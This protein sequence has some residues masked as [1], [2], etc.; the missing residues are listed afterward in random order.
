MRLLVAGF[1]LARF[2]GGYGGAFGAEGVF[3]ALDFLFW[4]VYRLILR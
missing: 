1:S 4:F 2:F 3:D